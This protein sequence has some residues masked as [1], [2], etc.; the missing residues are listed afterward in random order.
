MKKLSFTFIIAL[1][2]TASTWAQTSFNYNGD[3]YQ[4][5]DES[6]RT[7]K[8][9]GPTEQTGVF[10][11]NIPETVVYNEKTYTVTTLGNF[12]WS[13]LQ[14]T[15][16]TVPATVTEIESGAF[17]NCPKLKEINLLATTPATIG[18]SLFRMN[19]PDLVV[20]IPPTAIR[21]YQKNSSWNA[22]DFLRSYFTA[23]KLRYEVIVKEDLTVTI[24]GSEEGYQPTGVLNIPATVNYGD[25]TLIVSRIG[26]KAFAHCKLT[27]VNIPS[28]VRE[29]GVEAF[30]TCGLSSVA[31]AD[32][33]ETIEDSAFGYNSSLNQI[34]LPNS[35]TNLGASA[36]SS[37]GLT[38]VDIPAGVTS[39]GEG[40]FYNCKKLTAI[41]V[42]AANT[43]FCSKNGVLFNGDKTVLIQYPNGK[44]GSDYT[45]PESVTTINGLSFAFNEN[46]TSVTIGS[47]VDSI[48][49]V[50]FASCS[51][52]TEINVLATTP[53][54]LGQKPFNYVSTSI[55]VYVPAASLEAY[56]AAEGWK[57]F[58][59]LQERIEFLVNKLKYKITDPVAKTVELFSCNYTDIPT[60]VVD[61]PANVNYGS[62]T[63]SVTSMCRGMFNLVYTEVTQINIPSSLVVIG[64]NDMGVNLRNL[65]RINVDAA[66]PAFCSENGIL[67][68][69]DKNSLI[70]YPA[71]K[72]E[73]SYA[74][75]ES[76]TKIEICAFD[77]NE[78]IKQVTIP[79]NVT[80]IGSMAFYLC[81]AL[82]QVNIPKR[83][84]FI[85]ALAF[86]ESGITE[87]DIPA[88]VTDIETGAF[89]MCRELKKVSLGKGIKNIG[90]LAFD[91]CTALEEMTVHAV[92]PPTVEQD[93]FMDVSRDI[94]VYV[95]AE[96]LAVYQEA[97]VWKEFANLQAI[98]S[99]LDT[100]SMPESIRIY[101]GMLHN[102]EGL[103]VTLY[104]LAGR[105]AYDGRAAIVELPAGVYVVRCNGATKLRQAAGRQPA[106]YTHTSNNKN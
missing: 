64:K 22:F 87:I 65:E 59:A 9:M 1:L 34:T 5:I 71:K 69:K 8:Y 15:K 19:H 2:A 33:V 51:G 98:P 58:T 37:C 32:G 92:E 56:K 36:F 14:L 93:A 45:I 47:R 78:I 80:S 31:L 95:P 104:D 90:M 41:N 28:S 29:I 76:V 100:P 12:R 57:D 101:G 63:Y 73:I 89:S 7:V 99:G 50:A 10:E 23:N 91:D 52:L 79:E 77:N 42:N 35:L 70:K 18:E 20:T 6:A 13:I 84:N 38:Q 86:S 83:V 75:P 105:I 62:S 53:P 48:G 43:A 16:V 11:R 17:S 67:F 81:S 96:S 74:I 26:N 21:A 27:Q 30:F 66:N 106:I 68:S 60:G 55:P 49:D 46:L 4:V 40:V 3:K 103:R 24:R 54:T 82:E 72:P 102:P 94:P 44:S 25:L 88:S 85:G 39:I 61:I 97:D